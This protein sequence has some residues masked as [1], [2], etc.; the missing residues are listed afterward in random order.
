[1]ELEDG[2]E[3]YIDDGEAEDLYFLDEYST[4]DLLA[5]CTSGVLNSV[6]YNLLL[7]VSFALLQ[8]AVLCL[9]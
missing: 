8:K 6:R 4:S 9:S 7:T 3:H 1:M 5:S 2:F